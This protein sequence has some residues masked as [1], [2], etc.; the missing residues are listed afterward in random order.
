MVHNIINSFDIKNYIRMRGE[1]TMFSP[2]NM[3]GFE[4]FVARVFGWIYR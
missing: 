1:K 4:I 2:P 3:N